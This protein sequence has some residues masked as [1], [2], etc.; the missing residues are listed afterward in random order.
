[1]FA[2][3]FWAPRFRPELANTLLAREIS[4]PLRSGILTFG[5]RASSRRTRDSNSPVSRYSGTSRWISSKHS[6]ACCH[7][8]VLMCRCPRSYRA[9]ALCS[10]S[11]A[12]LLDARSPRDQGSS[13]LPSVSVRRHR[14]PLP[15]PG[16]DATGVPDRRAPLGDAG[17][18]PLLRSGAG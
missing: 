10:C 4:W 13:G 9:A 15:I 1:L 12:S 3:L 7:S 5:G 17:A 18:S 6:S 11:R 14:P 16:F 8:S 2:T